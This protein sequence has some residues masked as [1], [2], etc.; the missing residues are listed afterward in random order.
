MLSSLV[1]NASFPAVPFGTLLSF[2]FAV[3]FA[4]SN[5]WSNASTSAFSSGVTK[6][7]DVTSATFVSTAVFACSALA[8]ACPASDNWSVSNTPL[9]SASFTSGDVT[10]A[11][12]SSLVWSP[13][14]PAVPFGT[15]FS[16]S[17]AACFAFSNV[18]I[19]ASTSAFSSGVTKLSVFISVNFVSTAVFACSAFFTASVASDNCSISNTPLP[20]A[21]FTFG[22]VTDVILSSLV[23]NSVLPAVPFGTLFSFSFAVCFAFSNVLINASTSAFSSCVTKLSVFISFPLLSTSVFA[24]SA[25]ITASV[26]S[27]N[28]SISNTPLP[29]ASFT[30]GDV[31]DVIL[32]SLVCNSVL[33][34]VP[35]G[36]LSNFSLVVCF[37]V[38]NA[39]INASTSAFSFGV[40]KPSHVIS[41]NF[42]STA[43]FACSAFVTA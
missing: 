20:S 12:L 40:T 17:F 37:A 27:D 4:F 2:S 30:S 8:T 25:F 6:P 5:V 26:A 15:L 43:V 33:P 38:S 1:C 39:W 34:A 7:S 9:L 18:W 19:N 14:L 13:S 41:V 24:C 11:M 28:C 21:S 23:C 22:D 3:C 10:G 36:T 32:S 16:F 29:S 35:F 42:V 31:T